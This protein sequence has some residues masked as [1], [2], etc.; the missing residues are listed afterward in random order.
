MGKTARVEEGS[1]VASAN[2]IFL[3]GCQYDNAHKGA[4]L[5]MD[6]QTHRETLQHLESDGVFVGLGR[7]IF[8]F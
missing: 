2:M 7:E 1:E 5:M 6:R 8:D 3:L 4:Y